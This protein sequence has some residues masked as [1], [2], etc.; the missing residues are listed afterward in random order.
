MQYTSS[1]FA[2][3]LVGLFRW[4]LWPELETP[5]LARQPFPGRERLHTELPDPV[6]DRVTLPAARRLVQ[7]STWFRWLQRGRTH[8]YVLYILVAILLGFLAA[9]GAAG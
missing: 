1:S 2:D 6:L 9:R 3:G 8:A 7:A 5:R 4:A